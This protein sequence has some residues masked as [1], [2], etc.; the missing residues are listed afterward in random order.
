MLIFRRGLAQ[1]ALLLGALQLVPG[2]A[3]DLDI[4][5]PIDVSSVTRAQFDPTNPIPVLRL[6]PTPTALVQDPET[7]DLTSD[8]APRP[9]EGQST[10][11]CLAF[12]NGGWPTT[13]PITLYFSGALDESTVTQGI[14]LLENGMTPVPFTATIEDRP[15]PPSA[16]KDGGNGSSPNRTYTDADVPAGKQLV[17]SPM[18]ALKPSTRYVLFVKSSESAGLKDAGGKRV[19]PAALFYLLNNETPP[20]LENGT[21]TSALLRSS[22]EGSVLRSLFPGKTPDQLTAEEKMQLAAGVQ[23]SGQSLYR[24]YGFFSSIIT[25]LVANNVAPR[26]EIIFANAWKTADTGP[27][28]PYVLF[29]PANSIVPFPNT[30]LLTT[31]EPDGSLQVSISNPTNDPVVAGLNTLDGFSTT[32]PIAIPVSAPADPASIDPSATTPCTADDCKIVMYSVGDNGMVDDTSG[33]PLAVI[34]SSTSIAVVPVIPLTQKKTYV[35]ALKKGITDLDGA[36]LMSMQTYDFLKIPAPF[37][38]DQG[39]VLDA[40]INP[41]GGT[42]KDALECSTVA[43]TGMLASPEQVTATA[44]LLEV[45][46]QHQRW[47]GAFAALESATPAL[48]RTDVTM[49]FS[50]DTQSITDVV[51]FAAAAIERTEGCNPPMGVPCY[52]QV[53]GGAD[54][55]VGPVLDVR[56]TEQIAGAIGVVQNLCV[57]VCQSGAMAPAIT[58][59]QCTANLATLAQ[60]PLC[61]TAVQLVA[62][63][64]DRLRLYLLTTYD[65]QTGGPFQTNPGASGTFTPTSLVVP[66][67]RTIPMW[68]VTGTTTDPSAKYPVAIFQHG[69]GSQKEA[70]FYLANTMAATVV[71]GASPAGWATVMID[72]PFH[73]SRA[74]DLVNNTTGLPCDVD[75]DDV[76]C[77]DPDGPGPQPVACTGG[78]DGA[79][80]SSGTGFLGINLF[81]TR[82]N[83]RQATIDQLTMIDALKKAS[84]PGGPLEFLDTT[85]MGYVGQSLGGITGGNLAAYVSPTEMQGM[86]LN[87]GGGGLVY[88]V[89]L[90]TVPQISAPLFAGLAARGICELNEPGNPASGCKETPGFAR[91]KIIAQWIL[92]PGDPLGTSIG[93]TREL[94]DGRTP[95]GPDKVLIQMSLPDPVVPNDAS[96]ALGRSY[97][98]ALDGSDDNFQ[99][100]DF[101]GVT[102]PTSSGCHSFLLAPICGEC[103]VDTICNSFGA[104]QQAARFIASSGATVGSQVPTIPGLPCDNPCQ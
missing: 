12:V 80:D 78:C 20:V 48:P 85:K 103:L 62:S 57:P 38:D 35:I 5:D 39:N 17:I 31:Q 86:V 30:Q 14:V 96:Y 76:V 26:E 87:V 60:H 6:V 2:C 43:T 58:P 98:F 100:F 28:G 61:R 94:S 90:K 68:V 49:A 34:T 4:T 66:E 45:Q 81:A 18:A 71:P 37:I 82:D 22:V 56:G 52:S 79:Q 16:C 7:G 9:C 42:F 11:Q 91:F 74:S 59:D 67:A 55:I 99:I 92:D 75:P 50:Y 36:E 29:D 23:A 47:L 54:Q 70:G 84:Q 10:K 8:T 13:T 93:V 73:G 1:S 65:A 41:R 44:T 51:D 89:L 64:L 69:L 72:L 15:A 40:P 101:S 88:N 3:R 21:I 25:P 27:Q 77:A 32:A 102:A 19:E 95:I 46:L 104:Q 97:G 63:R 33:V 53:L 24:L 83:F